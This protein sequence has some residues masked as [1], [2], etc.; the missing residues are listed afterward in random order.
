[1]APSAVAVSTPAREWC[2]DDVPVRAPDV[3]AAFLD[4]EAVL[5]SIDQRRSV[6]LNESA[7]EMWAALDGHTTVGEI[8]GRLADV[9]GVDRQTVVNDLV[10][11]LSVLQ[12]LRVVSRFFTE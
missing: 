10:N 7:A 12:D 5:Y 4:G 6:L 11:S 9:H 3:C 1:M 2:A 8:A